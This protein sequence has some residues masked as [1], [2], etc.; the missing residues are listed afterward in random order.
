MNDIF[1]KK[2]WVW[3]KIF[4]IWPNPK[5]IDKT[6]CPAHTNKYKKTLLPLSIN[7]S[8]SFSLWGLSRVRPLA[9]SLAVS[10]T[11][12][13][14]QST[15]MA[16]PSRGGRRSPP[17]GSASGSSSR[18]RSYSGS[19]SRS[20][21]SSRSRS[22]SRSRSLSRSRS[23][24]RSF[25]SSSSPSRSASSRSPSAPPPKKRYFYCSSF[26]NMICHSFRLLCCLVA[27]KVLKKIT[28]S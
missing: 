20:R 26:S 14:T 5:P 12:S 11:H 21:S 25:S 3:V 7:F 27:K 24:S 10:L 9:L 22:V 16:K 17:S 1:L 19:D 2:P 6:H 18:S 13:Q 8:L 4:Q 28:K 15:P 23:R